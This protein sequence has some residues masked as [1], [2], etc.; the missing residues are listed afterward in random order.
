MAGDR[1]ID[2]RTTCVPPRA[3]NSDAVATTVKTTTPFTEEELM[4]MTEDILQ[5]TGRAAQQTEEFL[6]EIVYPLLQE[7]KNN[8]QAVDSELNV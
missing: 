7:N 5:F 2:R 1:R 6:T 8:Y 3:A 4:E